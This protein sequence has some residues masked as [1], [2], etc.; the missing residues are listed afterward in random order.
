M[1]QLF[2]IILAVGGIIQFVETKKEKYIILDL[3]VL[4][5][6]LVTP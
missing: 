6:H 4:V 5:N 2:V 3:V 1:V